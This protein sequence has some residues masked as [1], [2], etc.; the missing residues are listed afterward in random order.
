M[1]ALVR[2]LLESKYKLY[3]ERRVAN[4]AIYAYKVKN[5]SEE[6]LVT[7]ECIKQLEER[8]V[9][10]RLKLSQLRGPPPTFIN[11]LQQCQRDVE[12]AVQAV[13]QHAIA[14]PTDDS[15]PSPVVW[16]CGESK[17]VI[18]V[19]RAILC[20]L[21]PEKCRGDGADTFDGMDSKIE[22]SVKRTFR[23]NLTQKRIKEVVDEATFQTIMDAC[24]SETTTVGLNAATESVMKSILDYSDANTLDKYFTPQTAPIIKEEKPDAIKVETKKRKLE[25]EEEMPQLTQS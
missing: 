17:L 12:D 1:L 5:K 25:E 19:E 4:D 20:D 11:K 7:E 18:D 10:E 13:Y 14:H 16:S 15:E 2:T 21:L 22:L 8:L 23:T 9:E 24:K 3:H 6:E